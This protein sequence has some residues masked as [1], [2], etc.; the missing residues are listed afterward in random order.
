MAPESFEIVVIASSAGGI[1]ALFE[2]LA[3]LPD[4]TIPATVTGAMLYDP[5]G[6]RRDG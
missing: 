6:A 1:E 4:G 3:P 2:L 5:E